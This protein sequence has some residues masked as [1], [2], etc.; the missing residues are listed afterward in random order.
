[1]TALRYL[2][3]RG[4]AVKTLESRVCQHCLTPLAAGNR[5]DFC[6][7]GCR[8]VSELLRE[9]GLTRYYALR[10]DR[11]L[12]PVGDAKAQLSEVWLDAAAAGLEAQQGV[13]RLSLDVQGLQCG[14][15]V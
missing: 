7:L 9:S 2:E 15:C 12:A 1:M 6:C 4:E 14:A 3:P 8:H 13:K 5:D 11:A 10:G